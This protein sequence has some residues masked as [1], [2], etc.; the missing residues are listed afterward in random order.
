MTIMDAQ[1]EVLCD[2]EGCN[3]SV[4]IDL[5]YRYTSYSGA[6]GYYDS[7]NSSIEETLK[8]DHDWIVKDGKHFCCKECAGIEEEEE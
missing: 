6:D 7:K 1:V 3:D 8:N 4:Y 5:E 2:G